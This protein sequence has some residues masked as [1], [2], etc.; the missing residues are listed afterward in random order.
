MILLDEPTNHLDFE[1]VEALALALKES[2][3]TII[4]VSHN[5]TFVDIV[6]TGIIEVKNGKVAR[7]QHNYEEYVYHLE[8]NINEDLGIL[9]GPRTSLD[10]EERKK[11]RSKQKTAKKE[12]KK[13]EKEIEK[14]NQEKTELLQW[15][16]ENFSEFSEDKTKR[17]AKIE[18]EIKKKEEDWMEIE[19]ELEVLK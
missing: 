18:E 16:E 12:L 9:S 15:F 17:L 3:V 11:I 7:Y 1:T 14:L 6:A 4:F 5:R 13:L 19:L 2:N 8:Q 10:K